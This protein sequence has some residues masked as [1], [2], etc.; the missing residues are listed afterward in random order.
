MLLTKLLQERSVEL[1]L[2]EPASWKENWF[3]IEKNVS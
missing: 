1:P 3:W 2:K